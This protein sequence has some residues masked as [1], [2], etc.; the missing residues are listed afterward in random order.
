MDN[1]RLNNEIIMLVDEVKQKEE[2]LFA[3][4]GKL[5]ASDNRID[6]KE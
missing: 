1:N 3:L 2:N 5:Y 4:S 6:A